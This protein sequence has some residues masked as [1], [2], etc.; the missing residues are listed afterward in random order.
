M[1]PSAEDLE[2]AHNIFFNLESI[3][4]VAAVTL[5]ERDIAKIAKALAD[6]G[7][8]VRAQERWACA[9]VADGW[10]K[11]KSCQSHEE[12]PCCHVRTGA[13][14]AQAIRDREKP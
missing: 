6:K 1:T 14:I 2:K 5:K 3:Y 12:N 7:A 10:T 8:E 4:G 13:G 9:E 11:S